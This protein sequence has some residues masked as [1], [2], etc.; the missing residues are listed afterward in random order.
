MRRKC[1][2]SLVLCW[3]LAAIAP[4]TQAGTV[5]ERVAQG[6]P[7]NLG[8]P[9]CFGS[10][11]ISGWQWQAGGLRDG[12]VPGRCR[13]HRRPDGAKAMK[14]ALVP[15]TSANRI[16]AVAQGKVDLECGS[17]TNNAERRTEVAFAIPHFITGARLLVRADS[18]V[19]RLDGCVA[20]RWCAAG[21]T[22]VRFKALCAGQPGPLAAPRHCGSAR[23]PKSRGHGQNRRG[24][25]VRH[26][27]RALVWLACRPRKSRRRSRWLARILTTEAL[28]ARH[29]GRRTNPELKEVVDDTM[30]AL[31]YSRQNH[32]HT[33]PSGLPTP[34]RPR[35]RC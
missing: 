25:R 30:R 8:V 7:L 35:T 32:R 19:N 23:P 21:R 3:V 24:R 26:G 34:F 18:P 20:K 17:T 13:C 28:A 31:I 2:W 29:A 22:D 14:I 12:L 27:R 9:R 33:T 16:A 1:R 15:V 11:F 4:A 5:L 6:G 10:L